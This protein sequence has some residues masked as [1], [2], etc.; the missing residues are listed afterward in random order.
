MRIVIG[1]DH[2][3]YLMKRK[4]LAFAQQHYVGIEIFDAG[5]A[6]KEIVD[7]PLIAKKVTF[8][9]SDA[10]K[11]MGILICGSGIGMSIAAN[12][13]KNIRAALCSSKEYARTS[14]M[15]NNANVL[16]LGADFLTFDEAKSILN[17]FME[18][19]FSDE[20]RHSNRITML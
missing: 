3:G 7:Y 16:V 4:L 5:C 10:D 9:I 11:V 20:S 18:T 2:R 14:R 13:Y 15:H 12:R 8:Q 17:M 19:D 1:S 6:E